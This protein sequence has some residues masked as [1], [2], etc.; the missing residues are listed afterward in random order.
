MEPGA[1]VLTSPAMDLLLPASLSVPCSLTHTGLQTL[2]LIGGLLFPTPPS[3]SVQVSFQASFKALS[4][5]CL[6]NSLLVSQF[7]VHS[8][9]HLPALASRSPAPV[10]FWNG[11]PVG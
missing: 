9:G 5:G 6:S 2:L 11:L 3:A 8:P 4:P 1:A 10:C 7:K